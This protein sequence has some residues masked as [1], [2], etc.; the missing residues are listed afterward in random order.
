GLSGRY[1]QAPTLERFA[2]NLAAQRDSVTEIPTERWD[3]ADYPDIACRWGGF[4]DDALAFDP[5]FFSVSPNA[6]AYMDPQERLF[7]ESVW[8]FREDAGYTPEGLAPPDSPG[9]RADV[10][11]Y[12]GVTFY[13]YAPYGAAA[14]AAGADAPLN[15]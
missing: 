12:A 7:V 4:I 8:H 5:A 1:P 6:A 9:G 14:V 10:A 11:V 15:A 2:A 13:E 3:H